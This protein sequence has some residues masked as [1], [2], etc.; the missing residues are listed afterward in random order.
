MSWFDK[1]T[2]VDWILLLGLVAGMAVRVLEWYW[3]QNK[4]ASE[5]PHYLTREEF[6]Q[7]I[8]LFRLKHDE[9]IKHW[10]R[11]ELDSYV[12]IKQGEELHR[13]IGRLEDK[14]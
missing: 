9:D 11:S 10:V 13:R 3:R 5:A 8:E 14:Q 7:R 1:A 12:H 4:L 2:I 6:E